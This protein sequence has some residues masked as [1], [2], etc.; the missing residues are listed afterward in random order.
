MAVDFKS[1]PGKQV[2]LVHRDGAGDIV[3]TGADY[4]LPV[5]GE[6][7]PHGVSGWS[8]VASADNLAATASRAAVA[9]QSHYITGIAGS[10]S[11]AVAGKLLELKDG[12]TVVW[13]GYVHNQLGLTFAKPIRISAGAAASLTLAASGTAGVLG[14]VSLTG[15]TA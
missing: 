12:A 3:P 1:M 4:P 6:A 8:E 7:D 5:S 15:Y 9:G 14:A 10:F 2:G 11:A 13:R